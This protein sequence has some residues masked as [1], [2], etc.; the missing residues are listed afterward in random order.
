[1]L[2]ILFSWVL[3]AN[4]VTQENTIP[5]DTLTEQIN[6]IQNAH[7]KERHLLMNQLKIQLRSMNKEHRQKSIEQLKKSFHATVVKPT[8]QENKNLHEQQAKHQ[9][10][11]RQLRN[12]QGVGLG[13]G[14]GNGNK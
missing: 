1:L 9:P 4:D 13:N 7:P 8:P 2:L 14:Q 6:Q 5:K 10:K 3:V 11:H 12:K